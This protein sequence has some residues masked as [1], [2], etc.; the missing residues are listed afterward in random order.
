MGSYLND[1]HNKIKVYDCYIGGH[2]CG[3]VE[4]EDSEAA[5]EKAI[6]KYGMDV[7]IVL[8]EED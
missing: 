5:L 7:D 3:C 6:F 8:R 2:K 1:L 4:G